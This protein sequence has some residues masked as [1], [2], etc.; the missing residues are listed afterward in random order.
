MEPNAVSEDRWLPKSRVHVCCP[1]HP[2]RTVYGTTPGT[3]SESEPAEILH[4]RLLMALHSSPNGAWAPLKPKFDV[5][6][7]GAWPL[8]TKATALRKLLV[9]VLK[10][11]KVEHTPDV[12]YYSYGR[13][14][15][16]FDRHCDVE[17]PANIYEKDLTP[18]GPTNI[19]PLT[20]ITEQSKQAPQNLRGRRASQADISLVSCQPD[21]DSNVQGYCGDH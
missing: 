3:R 1:V 7:G 10:R 6:S 19:R 15:S 14:Y 9:T 17:M 12:P 13:P 8:A 4:L 20:E 18:E 11:N 16:I 5:E 21:F 2:F